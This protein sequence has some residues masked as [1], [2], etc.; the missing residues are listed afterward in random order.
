MR[1]FISFRDLDWLLLGLVLLLSVISIFEIY[2][3][4]LHTKFVGFETKQIFWLIGGLAGMFIF[5]LVNYHPL[6]EVKLLLIAAMAKYSSNPA[7][8]DLPR[9]NIFKAFLLIR[10]PMLLRLKQPDLG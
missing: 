2:S 8:K 6:N 4:T 3:A 7:G 1:R 5:S 10:R 9:S